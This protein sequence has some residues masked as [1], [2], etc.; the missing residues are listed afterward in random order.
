MLST[1][2]RPQNG[3]FNRL[4]RLLAPDAAV[5]ADEAAVL[6][7]TPRQIEGRDEVATFL[8]G[9]AAAALPVFVGDRPGAAWF[10]RPP[11]RCAGLR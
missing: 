4:L 9:S 5:T 6:A 2:K 1:S 8:N 3:D 10:V 7:G 11:E